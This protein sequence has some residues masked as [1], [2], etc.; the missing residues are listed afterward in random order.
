MKRF[1][2]RQRVQIV[3]PLHP[4]RTDLKGMTGT[5]VR[6]RRCD[7]LAWIAMDAPLLDIF[8]CFPSGDPR[9][10]HIVCDPRECEPVEKGQ[11]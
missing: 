7:D 3:T 10:D 4:E 11:P 2:N 5:V 8:R 6:L 9:A 1:H